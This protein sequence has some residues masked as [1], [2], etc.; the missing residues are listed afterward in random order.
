MRTR[1]LQSTGKVEWTGAWSNSPEEWT[2]EW[3]ERLNHS[4]AQK[5][6]TFKMRTYCRDAHAD[7]LD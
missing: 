1:S 4:F 3:M 2:H 6:V 7:K 5:N